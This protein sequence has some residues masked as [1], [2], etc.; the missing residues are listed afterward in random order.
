MWWEIVRL[1]G[2]RR[3]NEQRICPT[4]SKEYWNH[5]LEGGG[6]ECEGREFE[7]EI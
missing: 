1:T 5:I 2:V 7:Q 4:Y 6:G 3:S